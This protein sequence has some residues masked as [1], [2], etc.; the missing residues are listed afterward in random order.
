MA[1]KSKAP[2]NRRTHSAPKTV[3]KLPDLD[4]AKSAVLNSLSSKDAQRVYRQRKRSAGF[5]SS[6]LSRRERSFLRLSRRSYLRLFGIFSRFGTSVDGQLPTD[7]KNCS[8]RC[9]GTSS[10]VSY[11]KRR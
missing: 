10:S 5:G 9:F 7:S 4:Q 8:N 2:K 11:A 1:T 3:L 6:H